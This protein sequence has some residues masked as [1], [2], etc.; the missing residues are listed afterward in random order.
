MITSPPSNTFPLI[1]IALSG[2]FAPT[3]LAKLKSLELLTVKLY[4]VDPTLSTVELKVIESRA[5]SVV[6]AVKVTAALNNWLPL[7]V[8]LPAKTLLPTTTKLEVFT[9]LV[10]ALPATIFSVELKVTVPEY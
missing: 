4:G 2:L 3:D 5:V 7:V 8:M 10:I 9:E 6:S 1:A